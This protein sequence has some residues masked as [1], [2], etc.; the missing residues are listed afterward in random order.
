MRRSD[1]VLRAVE[2]NLVAALASIAFLGGAYALTV[3]SGWILVLMALIAAV[4]LTLVGARSHA[5]A[6]RRSRAIWLTVGANLVAA[7]V[8]VAIVPDML[9]PL[10]LVA[11][12]QVV[13]AI[14]VLSERQFAAAVGA[15]F[16]ALLLT[17]MAG[18]TLGARSL[19]NDVSMTIV[20]L[21]V[22]G[23][24]PAVAALVTVLIWQHRRRL[25]D[26]AA[27]LRRSR[28]RLA[29]VADRER[30]RLE[31]D[32]HDGAQQQLVAAAVQMPTIRA[33]IGMG[34]TPEADELLDRVE[35]RLRGA[36]DDLRRLARGLYPPVLATRGLADALGEVV[37]TVANPTVVQLG[38]VPRLPPEI[39]TAVY[40]CCLE[41]LQNATKHAPA[42]TITIE[43]ASD[44][45]TVTFSV[46]DDGP[47]FDPT[48]RGD[49]A[50]LLNMADRID[51]AGG[52]LTVTAW[53]GTGTV[54][55]GS[56]PIVGTGAG[57]P[58]GDGREA[59]AV[60]TG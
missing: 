19:R 54:V 1:P 5:L 14:D 38:V 53:A 10:V 51:A 44:D 42:S 29:T 31:R 24:V 41:A 21:V 58:R 12:L 55:A 36:I 45:T 23:A 25:A 30:R 33:L 47:G 8:V 18:R 2:F 46:A 40:Y 34:R 9:A 6:G 28:S 13:L 49:G 27:E 11:L 16:V 20:D 48:A 17:A 4:A 37:T 32:L 52:E 7:P 59:L 39:E 26:Q 56:V 35:Q 43:L 15:A 57:S 50:G 3:R 22:V 60:P